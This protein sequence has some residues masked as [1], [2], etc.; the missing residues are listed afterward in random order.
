MLGKAQ[1][2]LQARDE[3][4]NKQQLQFLKKAKERTQ[5]HRQPYILLPNSSKST[6]KIYSQQTLPA[7]KSNRY[8]PSILFV[9]FKTKQVQMS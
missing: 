1:H 4:L 5:R 7:T 9:F 2:T 3:Q 8:T 6:I